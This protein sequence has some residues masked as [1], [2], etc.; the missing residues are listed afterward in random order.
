MVTD[1]AIGNLKHKAES[2]RVQ[3][4]VDSLNPTRR[5]EF[6]AVNMAPGTKTF[7]LTE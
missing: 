5:Q 4:T 2:T 1:L 6:L 7:A 3:C